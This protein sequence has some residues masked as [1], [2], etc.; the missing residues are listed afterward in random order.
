[1]SCL[2]CLVCGRPVDPYSHKQ[3]SCTPAGWLYC[4][5]WVSWLT[6]G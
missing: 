6:K 1:M 5:R 2:R 4:R 3:E